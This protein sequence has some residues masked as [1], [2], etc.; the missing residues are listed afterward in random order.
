MKYYR[1]VPATR[2]KRAGVDI[3]LPKDWDPISGLI[4]R[5]LARHMIYALHDYAFNKIAWNPQM[6]KLDKKSLS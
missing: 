2:A 4:D 5:A 1:L 6:K 3:G